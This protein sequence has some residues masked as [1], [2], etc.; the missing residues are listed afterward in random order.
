MIVQLSKFF[1]E[2]DLDSFNKIISDVPEW[3]RVNHQEHVDVETNIAFREAIIYAI[4][5]SPKYQHLQSA[6][7]TNFPDSVAIDFS[8]SGFALMR[9]PEGEFLK[10]HEDHSS[11]NVHTLKEFVT[12]IIYINDDYE[13]G[14]LF[15]SDDDGEEVDLDICAGDLVLMSASLPHG[16]RTVTKG[17]KYLGIWLTGL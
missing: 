2:E 8:K 16:S 1:N 17:N 3:N 5:R 9:M 14:N 12:M 15:Y 11:D 7:A 4:L 10:L 6:L 13:G